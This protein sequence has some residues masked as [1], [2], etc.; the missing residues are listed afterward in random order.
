VGAWRTVAAADAGA[1]HLRERVFIAAVRPERAGLLAAAHAD[2]GCDTGDPAH[3]RASERVDSRPVAA[4][5]ELPRRYDGPAADGT[6]A[7]I[8]VW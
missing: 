3:A 2:T 5:V 8:R 6:G 7:A 1:P 4:P